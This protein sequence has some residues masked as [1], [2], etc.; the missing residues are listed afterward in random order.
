MQNLV[1][2]RRQQQIG[3]SDH[4]HTHANGHHIHTHVQPRENSAPLNPD[5]P[6][7]I[8]DSTK[9]ENQLLGPPNT[10][11]QNTL[12]SNTLVNSDGVSAAPTSEKFDQVKASKKGTIF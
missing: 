6:A 1:A 8:Q 7:A 10:D 12:P 5:Q 4:H 11:L 2:H 9:Q 3:S